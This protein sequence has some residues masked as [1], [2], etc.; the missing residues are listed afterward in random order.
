VIGCGRRVFAE[1]ARR[2][3]LHGPGVLLVGACPQLIQPRV[4]RGDRILV[5]PNR[6]SDPVSEP[7]AGDDRDE[8]PEVFHPRGGDDQTT[9]N[10]ITAALPIHRPSLPCTI[11]PVC[12]YAPVK[13]RAVDHDAGKAATAL[14]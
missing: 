14:V 4:L 8:Q 11:S 7:Q 6:A 5:S 1:H 13:I 12:V 2:V 10:Y 9:R 3:A